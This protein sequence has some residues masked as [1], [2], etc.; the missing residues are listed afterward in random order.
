MASST[1]N[2][3]IGLFFAI[4]RL[5]SPSVIIPERVSS[6]LKIRVVPNLK[7]SIFSIASSRLAPSKTIGRDFP[8]SMMS[9][10]LLESICPI[11]PPG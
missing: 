11:F 3:K 4:K 6:D 8:V 7:R 9:L 1:V 5:K 10:T 2:S